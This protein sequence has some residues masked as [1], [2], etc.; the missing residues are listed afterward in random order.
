MLASPRFLA[1]LA[2]A[3]VALFVIAAAFSDHSTTSVD[4][5]IWW[6]AIGGFVLLIVA[7]SAVLVGFLRSRAKRPPRSRVRS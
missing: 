4:G 7:A 6:L 3:D 1:R 5:I 2:M